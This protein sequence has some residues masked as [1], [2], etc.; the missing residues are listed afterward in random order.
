MRNTRAEV[1]HG[2]GHPLPPRPVLPAISD[3]E[4]IQ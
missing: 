1:L 2:E 4:T 3:G